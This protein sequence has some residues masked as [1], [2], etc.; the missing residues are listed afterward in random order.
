LPFLAWTILLAV[1]WLF[2]VATQSAAE[3]SGLFLA[4]PRRKNCIFRLYFPKVKE[5]WVGLP[6]QKDGSDLARRLRA[7]SFDRLE[8]WTEFWALVE[9]KAK[10]AQA[11]QLERAIVI[12]EA[13]GNA[14][15]AI[16][17]ATA[18]FWASNP[19]GFVTSHWL[20]L[21]G[22]VFL[23]LAFGRMHFLQVMRQHW[24]MVSFLMEFSAETVLAP[25]AVVADLKD[26]S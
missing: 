2:G 4:Y 15:A 12:K 17:L 20:E 26:S 24:M 21:V 25:G 19:H 10:G 16:I 23:V 22:A 18:I 14:Y 13:C 7:T 9:P 1:G 3:V 11:K 8:E 6:S 5:Q